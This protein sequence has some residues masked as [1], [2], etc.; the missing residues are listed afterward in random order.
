MMKDLNLLYG[1]VVVLTKRFYKV[2]DK[3]E[4]AIEEM[5]SADGWERWECE[6]VAPFKRF[7]IMRTFFLNQV[8]PTKL[9]E[10]L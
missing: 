5:K 10:E 7:S 4:K 3:L 8:Y 9:L 2:I 6:S 1:Q